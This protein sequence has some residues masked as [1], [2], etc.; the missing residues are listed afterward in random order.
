MGEEINTQMKAEGWD[1]SVFDADMDATKQ[2][3]QF[4]TALMMEPDV[5]VYW[6]RDSAAAVEDVKK[7][8]EAGVPVI[9][10]NND[11]DKT[12]WDYTLC[13]V[14]P[15]QY[16]IGYDL[17]TY[18]MEYKES[19]NIAIVDGLANN[20]TYNDRYNGF[21]DAIKDNPD[22]KVLVHDYCNADRTTAQTMTENYLTGFPEMDTIVAFSDNFAIGSINAITAANRNDIDVFSID[23]MQIGFDAINNGTMVATVLQ[24]PGYQIAKVIEVINDVI[25]G[26][27]TVTERRIFSGHYVVDKNNTDEFV[28]AY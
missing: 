25:V 7:A 12:G 20:T 28:P 17:A 19:A 5:I 3:T 1:L 14:G 27:G 9:M 11:V 16:G 15:D 10:L 13:F 8:A 2:S 21:M 18:M 22:Y 26:G 24:T 23:G 4:E 6:C